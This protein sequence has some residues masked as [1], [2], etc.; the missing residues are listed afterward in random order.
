MSL[1]NNERIYISGKVSGT[2]DYREKFALK[3]IE[4]NNKG[5]TSVNPVKLSKSIEDSIGAENLKWED[6]MRFD[7]GLMLTCTSIYML[8]DW[9]ES[10]G[11]RLEHDLATDL[12]YKIIYEDE[13]DG[14]QIF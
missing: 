5:Y 6:Y 1:M 14:E 7:I 8:R 13:N 10:K 4:L 11:A 2:S 12:N 9:K 3:E